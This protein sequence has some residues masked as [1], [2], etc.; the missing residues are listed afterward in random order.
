LV[1]FFQQFFDCLFEYWHCSEKRK[2]SSMCVY[3][4]EGA[5]VSAEQLV[6]FTANAQVV[7]TLY[8]DDPYYTSGCVCV[9]FLFHCMSVCDMCVINFMHSQIFPKKN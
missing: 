9:F 6:T 4:D 5:G 7:L 8:W 3:C 1:G 2:C